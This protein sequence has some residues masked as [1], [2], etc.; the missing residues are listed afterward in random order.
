MNKNIN[1]QW[2][3][4]PRVKIRRHR[5][6]N[7]SW[8]SG[9][10]EPVYAQADTYKLFKKGLVGKRTTWLYNSD[11]TL[12]QAIASYCDFKSLLDKYPTIRNEGHEILDQF[13][14][15]VVLHHYLN[16]LKIPQSKVEAALNDA[17]RRCDIWFCTIS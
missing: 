3:P 13:D 14:R 10:P 8:V 16:V 4:K 6:T 5:D 17:D 12:E 15:I 7:I 9:M 1:K 11:I 2:H